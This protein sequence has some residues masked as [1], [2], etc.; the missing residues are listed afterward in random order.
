M[1]SQRP[2]VRVFQWWYCYAA[3]FVWSSRCG[4]LTFGDVTF[5]YVTAFA[6]LC[7]G[8]FPVGHG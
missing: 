7:G 3:G 1:H 6:V 2:D 4:H 8:E 5:I